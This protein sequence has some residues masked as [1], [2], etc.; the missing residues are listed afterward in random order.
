MLHQTGAYSPAHILTP[1]GLD[2]D[3]GALARFEREALRSGA[4]IW[5]AEKKIQKP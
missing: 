5:V 3:P 2:A 1:G 4:D